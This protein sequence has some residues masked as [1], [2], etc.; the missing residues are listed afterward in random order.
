MN[1][2]VRV[3]LAIA[4]VPVLAYAQPAPP[5]AACDELRTLVL[6][7]NSQAPIQLDFASSLTGM[8]AIYG[9][10]QCHV[11]YQVLLNRKKII[12]G[13]VSA[14][15]KNGYPISQESAAVLLRSEVMHD[16]MKSSVLSMIPESTRRMG[17]MPYM[18]VEY[19]LRFDDDAAQAPL[20]V[21]VR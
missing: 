9:N 19:V 12:E 20:R 7:V 3:G 15:A 14:S 5:R 17:R 11:R 21:R 4:L 16:Q 8:S 10:G 2:R 1:I 6:D 13:L 18:N